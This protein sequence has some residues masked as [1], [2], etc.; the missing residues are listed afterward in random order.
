MSRQP[1]VSSGSQHSAHVSLS[2]LYIPGHHPT[3]P[4]APLL[5][6]VTWTP[7]DD[8]CQISLNGSV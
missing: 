7:V 2:R 5:L 3:Q 8:K 4:A 6:H 1:N